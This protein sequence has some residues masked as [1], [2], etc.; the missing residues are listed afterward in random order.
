MDGHGEAVATVGP[1]HAAPSD[2]T[3]ADLVN[4]PSQTW[5]PKPINATLTGELALQALQSKGLEVRAKF[6]DGSEYRS[7][8]SGQV[9]TL[10]PM[11]PVG[12][13]RRF[14]E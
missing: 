6:P 2:P 3:P 12:W 11:R 9:K 14:F 13:W 1:G 7:T 5:I 4:L 8:G 10:Q